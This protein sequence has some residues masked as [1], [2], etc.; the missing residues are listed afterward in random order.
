MDSCIYVWVVVKGTQK[1][2]VLMHPNLDKGK[3]IHYEH[4]MHYI[5]SSD[6]HTYLDSVQCIDA[7][8]WDVVCIFIGVGEAGQLAFY[9]RSHWSLHVWECSWQGEVVTYSYI[10][11]SV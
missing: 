11:V 8:H 10:S 5:L 3:T 4:C 6:M 7:F 9:S 2:S 1:S